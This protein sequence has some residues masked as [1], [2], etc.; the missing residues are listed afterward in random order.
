MPKNNIDQYPTDRMACDL[1]L[2]M[3]SVGLGGISLSELGDNYPSFES[4]P[5]KASFGAPLQGDAPR[6][7]SRF[8]KRVK[9]S[10]EQRRDWS[11]VPPSFETPQAAPQDEVALCENWDEMGQ[12]QNRAE[13]ASCY[14][15][16]IDPIE[17][18]RRIRALMGHQGLNVTEMARELG[19]SRAYIRNHLRLLDLPTVIQ[20]HVE[21]GRLMEGHARAIAKMRDPE[22]MA[23]LIIRR[24]LSVR[25]AETMAR[26]LR[27]VGPDGL[28]LRDTAIP[29]TV[30]VENLIED[31][32]G[33]KVRVKDRAGRGQI[34]ISYK[35]PEQ[36]Q[37]IVGR[38]VRTFD[39]LGL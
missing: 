9:H 8:A 32:L 36:F 21:H 2:L 30:M 23:R 17:R 5:L 24:R 33:F 28:L 12:L 37:E 27:Y 22:A 39:G 16:D 10:N 6:S 38:L 35:S 19:R 11:F 26:R 31:A 13:L 18:A 1:S 20:E 3:R 15:R 25:D 14:Q 34:V 4:R 7:G 29:N